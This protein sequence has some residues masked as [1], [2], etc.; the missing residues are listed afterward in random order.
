[1]SN[2]IIEE[3]DSD[4]TND[5]RKMSDYIFDISKSE[6]CKSCSLDIITISSNDSKIFYDY[7]QTNTSFQKSLYAF[8]KSVLT[9]F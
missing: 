4:T 5:S 6:N 3:Y 1:M 9:D 2:I 7:F 8:I